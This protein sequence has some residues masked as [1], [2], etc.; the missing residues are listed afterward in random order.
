MVDA[1]LVV[2]GI[3]LTGIVALVGIDQVARHFR[4][5]L[6]LIRDAAITISRKTPVPWQCDE[7]LRT[8]LQ[9]TEVVAE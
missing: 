9:E 6:R 2:L 8:I 3:C 4:K 1:G 7:Q 5:K